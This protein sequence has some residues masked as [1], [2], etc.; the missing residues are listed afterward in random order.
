[1]LTKKWQLL[2]RPHPDAFIGGQQI[3]YRFNEQGD[4]LSCVN[5]QTLHSFSF[6]WEIAVVKGVNGLGQFAGLR[7]D[8]PLTNDVEVFQTDNE[9]NEFIERAANYFG[10]TETLTKTAS[11]K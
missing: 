4:G 9:A 3:I 6:G 1:M 7:Y 5:G 8:T 11:K 2:T 10:A